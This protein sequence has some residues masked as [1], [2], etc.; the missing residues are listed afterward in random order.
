LI[1]EKIIGRKFRDTVNL[2]NV[3]I[4]AAETHHDVAAPAAGR[5][6]YG[7]APTTILGLVQNSKFNKF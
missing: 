5:K 2:S 4:S 6:I 7:L 3:I 1:D